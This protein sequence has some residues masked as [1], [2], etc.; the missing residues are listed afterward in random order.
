[1]LQYVQCGHIPDDVQIGQRWKK[2]ELA[3]LSSSNCSRECNIDPVSLAIAGPRDEKATVTSSVDL[4]GNRPLEEMQDLSNQ[5][6]KILR[7][8]NCSDPRE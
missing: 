4:G 1:M 2:R 6:G 5:I 7:W 3:G 8:N